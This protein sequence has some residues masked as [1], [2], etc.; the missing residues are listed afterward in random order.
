[1]K[2]LIEQAITEYWGERCPDYEPSCPCCITWEQYDVMYEAASTLAER[3][4]KIARGHRQ[5]GEKCKG[6]N[7]F[8][9]AYGAYKRA[10]QH[11]KIARRYLLSLIDAGREGLYE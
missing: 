8:S 9:H 5:V 2:N 6:D 11:D 1:M 7:M 3:H 4:Q 10:H